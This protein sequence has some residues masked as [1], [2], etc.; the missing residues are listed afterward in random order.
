MKAYGVSG[1]P[2]CLGIQEIR[3]FGMK[4]SAGRLRGKGGDY[5]S[6]TRKSEVR[7][8]V[9]RGFKKSERQRISKELDDFF[10]NEQ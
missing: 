10:E 6:Y 1:A 5:R 3:K 8:K 4:S 2:E 7:R 9:R